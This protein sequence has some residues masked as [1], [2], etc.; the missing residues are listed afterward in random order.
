VEQG[1][2]SIDLYISKIKLENFRNYNYLA[3]DLNKDTNLFYGENSSGK[4]NIIEAI[5]YIST[6]KSFRCNNDKYLVNENNNYFRIEINQEYTNGINKNFKIE[7]NKEINKRIITENNKNI[8]KLSDL[9][10]Q[11]PLVLFSPEHINMIS[12]EPLLRRKFIDNI[13]ISADKEYYILISKY[14]KIVYQRNYVLKSIKEHR[15]N[16]KDIDI[17]NLQLKEYSEKIINKR[18]DAIERINEIINNNF[19][20]KNI[21]I[22][23]KYRQKIFDNI[24][25]LDINRYFEL[26]FEKYFDEEVYRTSTL[27]GPHRDDIEILLNNKSLKYFGSEGQQR[28][29]CIILKLAEGIYIKE[30]KE[31]Y[32][33]VLLDDFTSE[34]DE[35]NK[36]FISEMFNIFRQIII[37]TTNKENVKN[38]KIDKC[39]FVDKGKVKDIE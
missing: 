9:I 23:L 2:R 38:I 8:R 31:V 22:E 25:S 16:K 4:T 6:G 39:F 35:T 13:L 33:I 20:K 7:Y 15:T 11:I 36:F 19:S 21:K 30:K 10:G 29:S 27:I 32:P 24:D 18:I 37:T 14:N 34:L 3:L 12:G 1:K 26:F 17:W 5:Y 28:L